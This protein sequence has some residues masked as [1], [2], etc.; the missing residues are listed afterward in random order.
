[1]G[2]VLFTTLTICREV[3]CEEDADASASR[4]RESCR[5]SDCWLFRFAVR[6]WAEPSKE[7]SFDSR[8]ERRGQVRSN[9]LLRLGL[10]LPNK[11]AQGGVGQGKR[12][13]LN[14]EGL[15]NIGL[16]LRLLEG[17]LRPY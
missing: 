13:A 6:F 9:A 4:R 17:I 7:N 15:R 8:E 5:S 12:R 14:D 11:R 16:P 10:H 1:M 3:S 2:N